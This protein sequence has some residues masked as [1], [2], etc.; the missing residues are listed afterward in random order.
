MFRPAEQ[1]LAWS[2]PRN[3]NEAERELV[4]FAALISRAVHVR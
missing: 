4:T 1:D 3:G 2:Y